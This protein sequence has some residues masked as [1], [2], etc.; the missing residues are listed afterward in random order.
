M[1]AGTDLRAQALG[2]A[3]VNFCPDIR[4]CLGGKFFPGIRFLT[5]FDQKL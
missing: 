3:G 1:K 5:I 4:F 2:F